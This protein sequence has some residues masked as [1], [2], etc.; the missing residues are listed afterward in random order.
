MKKNFL[1]DVVPSNQKRSIRDIP[2]PKGRKDSNSIQS[3]VGRTHIKIKQED[4]YEEPAKMAAHQSDP[5]YY[6]PQSFETQTPPKAVFSTNRFHDDV[7]YESKDSSE[8]MFTNRSV[9]KL[10]RVKNKKSFT[11][12]SLI[13]GVS[14]LA[15]IILFMIFGRHNATLTLSAKEAPYEISTAV[16]LNSTSPLVTKTKIAKTATRTVPATEEKQI[17]QLAQGRIKIINKHKETP[18]ELV[19]NTRFQAPNGL[20]Y[21]IRESIEIPGY[22]M[23][24][25]TLIPGTLEVEV[26]ADSVGEEYNI[27]NTNFTIP[28]FSGMEQ[29]EKITAET[30]GSITGG[31]IGIRKVVSAKTKENI[32]KELEAEL[33][34]Q[35]SNITKDSTEYV[36]V[37]DLSTISYSETKDEAQGSSVTLTIT[38]TVNAY[39]MVKQDLFN[40]IG[41]NVV[42]GATPTNMYTLNAAD[43]MYTLTE[44]DIQIAGNT[45][46]SAVI[47][48]EALKQE[49]ANK[50]RSEIATIVDKHNSF[51][52]LKIDL[53]PIWAQRFPEDTS[54]IKVI[55]NE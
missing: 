35:I 33:E 7:N 6:S 43:L 32:E 45:T 39:S 20:I 50:K 18:Q 2:L 10:S 46:I 34:A 17:E 29:F 19:K 16:T 36:L 28:G 27:S 1:Q 3:K 8:K 41:Q 31:Y 15:F 14:V 21:R 25:E 38:A 51:E 52:G 44:D 53:N 37:P 4:S 26:Y 48:V 9:E 5:V 22:T 23:S 11:T 55:I 54:K 49:F 42:T 24:G 12:K 40:F 30:A 13:T 47:D